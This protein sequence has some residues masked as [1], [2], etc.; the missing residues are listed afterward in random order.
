MDTCPS[1]GG[2]CDS[3]YVRELSDRW[4]D[5]RVYY[6]EVH[7]TYPVRYYDSL[8]LDRAIEERMEARHYD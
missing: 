6:C 8:A 1:C 2:P 7:D 3:E 4:T 5:A